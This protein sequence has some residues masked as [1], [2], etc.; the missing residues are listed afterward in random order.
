MYKKDHQGE[1]KEIVEDSGDNDHI[2]FQLRIQ[3]RGV[4][5]ATNLG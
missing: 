2:H 4:E 1:L 5:S 3:S